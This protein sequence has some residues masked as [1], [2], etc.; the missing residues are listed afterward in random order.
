[1]NLF[2]LLA[3][4]GADERDDVRMVQFL[5]N[6]YFW[7][8]SRAFRFGKSGQADDAPSNLSSCIVIDPS[9]NC[10]V[11]S[12]SQFLIESLESAAGRRLDEFID[13]F[14]L[15]LVTFFRV[16]DLLIFVILLRFQLACLRTRSTLRRFLSHSFCMRCTGHVVRFWF[17]FD[18]LRL[19]IRL[20]L[21]CSIRHLIYRRVCHRHLAHR[22]V[23]NQRLLHVV[24]LGFTFLQHFA[25]QGNVIGL[26][27]DGV[28]LVIFNN[29]SLVSFNLVI[30]ASGSVSI[31]LFIR[32]HRLRRGK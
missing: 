5:D 6:F 7:F 1:M 13:D 18:G 10:L 26:L 9:I 17:W 3:N 30:C 31:V 2:F 8:Y 21:I 25:P 12:S 24:I 27:H 16:F 4:P 20:H 14:V 15:I 32:V 11:G 29:Y 28:L 23:G 19:L 22:L